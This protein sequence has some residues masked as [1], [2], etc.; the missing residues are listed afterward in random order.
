MI[1]PSEDPLTKAALS[2]EKST[3]FTASVWPSNSLLEGPWI[4]SPSPPRIVKMRIVRSSDA[5]ARYFP[6]DDN[7][8]PF[9]AP[10]WTSRKQNN[11]IKSKDIYK[12]RILTTQK[13][14]NFSFGSYSVNVKK[15]GGDLLKLFKQ[16]AILESIFKRSLQHYEVV[17]L[18]EREKTLKNLQEILES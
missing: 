2:V 6:S 8:H 1:L 10:E 12:S 18:L 3:S 17:Y 11:L 4:N 5:D 7:T 9:I 15:S 14:C 13:N 16:L